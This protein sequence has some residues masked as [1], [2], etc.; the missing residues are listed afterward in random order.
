MGLGTQP[1]FCG[2]PPWSRR[3]SIGFGVILLGAAVAAP[4]VAATPDWVLPWAPAGAACLGA[5]M[6]AGG[7]LRSGRWRMTALTAGGLAIGAASLVVMR[8]SDGTLSAKPLAQVIAAQARPQDAV[9]TYNVYPHGLPFYLRR[10]IDKI[11]YWIGE[12]HYAKRDPANAARFGDDTDIRELP[13]NQRRA[14]V[15][16][17]ARQARHFISLTAPGSIAD[18]GRYG[19]WELAEFSAR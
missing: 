19:P 11:I 7:L 14:F 6:V 5:S 4:W 8:A 13:L 3:L 2:L 12:L 16:L 15:A 9:W 10:P 18:H 17:R 1:S